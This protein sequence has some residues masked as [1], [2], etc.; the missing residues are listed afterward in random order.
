MSLADHARMLIAYNAWANA[1]VLDAM[2]RLTDDQLNENA[3]GSIA[4]AMRHVIGAE[5]AWLSRWSGEPP[6]PY[7]LISREGMRAAADDSAHRLAEFVAS[8]TDA[9]WERVLDYRDSSGD[10]QSAPLGTLITHVVNHGTLH[11]GEAGF[12]L[13]RHD[14]SPGDLDFVYWARDHWEPPRSR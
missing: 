13:A 9:G 6:P 12:L 11:R 1:T 7:A 5:A 14:A 10:A 3:G 8:L 4:A 2:D